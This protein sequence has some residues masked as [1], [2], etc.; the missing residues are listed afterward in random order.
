MGFLPPADPGCGFVDAKAPEIGLWVA[1]D[2]R[3]RG[4]RRS[5][6]NELVEEADGCGIGQ[7]SLSVE[8][9]NFARRLYEP[10]D[11]LMFLGGKPTASWCWTW[12][13]TVDVAYVITCAY[14]MTA[15]PATTARANL[16]RLIDQ[17][18]EESEPL[19]ITGQRGNAVL[20]GEGDWRAIQETLFIESIPGM[21]A[22]IR[23]AREESIEAGS[24]ELPW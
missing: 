19:T 5:L 20:V 1:D 24:D 18:N 8:K 13:P 17:V 23:E 22:S 12:D 7:L 16:Y 6:L 10:W 11:S 14:C 3:G 4:L 21:T 2:C 15:I 9:E